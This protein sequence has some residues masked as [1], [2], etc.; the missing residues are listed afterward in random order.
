MRLTSVFLGL[1]IGLFSGTALAQTAAERAACQADAEKLCAGVKPGGG[2]IVQ[3]LAKQ[4]D[5][6]SPECR[7]VLQS[8]MPK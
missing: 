6:L 5:K 8:H 3:C 7:K 2:R 1:S 4:A